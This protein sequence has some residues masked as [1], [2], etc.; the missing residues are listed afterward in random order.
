M[1]KNFL[2]L[3][4]VLIM[5]ISI[6]GCSNNQKKDTSSQSL[7]TLTI[8]VMPDLDSLPLI[9]AEHNGYF[10]QEGFQVKLEHFKSASDRDTA[11]Q[12][13]KIHGAISDMLSVVFFNDNN[14]DVKITSKTEGS[15]KLISGKNS[16]ISKIEQADG[17]SIG[18]SKNT[19]IEYLT[20]RI[21][22]SSN[23][24]VNSQKKVAIPK[25]PTR[26]EMLTNGK[27]DMAT[28]P[29]PLA[30]TAISA[31][32]KI[33]SS[34][35]KLGINP[36]VMLFTKDAVS[37]K[38]EEIKSFYR[39]YNKAVEYLNKEKPESYID[40]VI[41]EAGFPDT[42]KSTLTIPNYS[43]ASMPPEKE[44]QEVMTWLKAKKLTTNN[45]KLQ[46]LS[47]SSFIK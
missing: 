36:G 41:K 27:L 31:G 13:G 33:L 40:F 45:Y 26:L 29:E 20:D 9:I 11:L 22:E 3:M 12:T 30:S 2:T 25:I 19:I 39:A 46:D 8:G 42:I 10:K 34:S 38:S 17:K 18:I 47:N 44:L 4:L 7:K 15:F 14:F 16:N 28:L 5:S 43:K 37:S 1:K 32:G 23:I 24:D 6:I 21:I 35:D